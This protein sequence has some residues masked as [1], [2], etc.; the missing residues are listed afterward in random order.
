M[1][2]QLTSNSGIF[3]VGQAGKVSLDFLFDGGDYRGELAIFSLKGMEGLEVGSAAFIKEASRRALSNSKLGYVAISDATEGAKFSAKLGWENNYNA[4]TYKGIKSFSMDG[5]DRFAVML[6]PQGTVRELYNNPSRTDN[7]RPLFSIDTANPNNTTQFYQLNEAKGMGNT[8]MF[9]DRTIPNGSDRDFNDITFQLIGATGEATS[10]DTVMPAGLDWRK[11]AAGKQIIDYASRPTYE[12]GVFRVDASGQVGIDYL[13]DGGA[14][15]GE[16]AIFS[17]KGMENLKLDSPAFAQEAARRALSNSTLGRIVVRDAADKAKFSAKYIWENDFNSGTYKGAKTVAMNPGEDFAV[18]LVQNSTVQDL[19]SNINNMW[20]NGRLPIFSI[21]AANGSTNNRQMVD[22]TGKGNT[23]AMEDAR[24]SWGNQA[25]KD[26][27]DIIFKVT[28][29][30]GIAHAMSQEINSGRDWSQSPV[31]KEMLQDITRPNFSGGV[32]DVGENG[33]VRIDFLYDGGWFNKGELAIFSLDGMEEFK[34]GSQAFIQEAARRSLTNSTQGYV[35]IKDALEGAKFSDKVPWENV[36]NSG[37]YQGVK[38]F[39]MESRG[40]FAFMLVQNNSVAAI[41]NNPNSISQ[42]GNMPIFSIP[43]ANAASKPVEMVKVGNRGTYAFEDVRSDRSASDKDY[44]DLIIQVK[45]AQSDLPLIDN[46][47]N[48]NRDWRNNKVG[49]DIANYTNRTEF[50][51]GVLTTNNTG[52]VEVEFLYDGGYYRGEVGIFSLAGMDSYTPGSEAFIREATRRVQSNSAQGYVVAQDP[53][54]GAKFTGGIDWETNFN[55]GSFKGVKVLNLNPNDS[56]GIMQVPNGTIAE[57]AKNPKQNGVKRPL[58]SMLDANPD[59]GFQIGKIDMVGGSTIV[60]LEDQRLDGQSDRDYNDIILRFKGVEVSADPLDRV[61]AS[62]KDWRATVMG[63]KLFDYVNARDKNNTTPEA[64]GEQSGNYLHGTRN[65]DKLLGNTGNDYLAGRE[66]KDLLTGG[67]GK[68]FLV[69][70]AGND[71]FKFTSLQ[72]AGDIISDFS[73][74]DRLDLDSLFT[75]FKYKGSN[76]V[77]DGYLQ[78]QQV[79]VDTQVLISSNGT[80]A[81]WVR[82]ATVSNVTASTLASNT[83]F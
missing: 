27:N 17:L 77:A 18:M 30:K 50:E 74:G 55:E 32:F 78:F 24:L 37:A 61:M 7:R 25:D 14:Y 3:T 79:G 44:N 6:V 35:V 67:K 51:S 16:L 19:Y 21:P 4:G 72:D 56:F 81:D 9:E 41:A 23:F 38:T 63:E 69:G 29:A 42:Y 58:F 60:A 33:K 10:V 11:T 28:G 54:E 48:P 65:H 64:F 83:V 13:F 57:V 15:Q 43:E 47:L 8:F 53:I 40:H 75:S 36:F 73:A 26:Y 1:S 12:T 82:L 20:S 62:G 59:Y 49:T 70:G 45:G 68:D 46:H 66:G 39:Q 34:V 31:G 80:H 71:T 76:P 22:V 2:Q 5:G 52:R